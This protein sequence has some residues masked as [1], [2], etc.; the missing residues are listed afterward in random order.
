MRLIDAGRFGEWRLATCIL[1]GPLGLAPCS[2]R[3]RRAWR[4]HP[5]DRDQ[6]GPGNGSCGDRVGQPSAAVP[7]PPPSWRDTPCGF[8]LPY[9]SMLQATVSFLAS[10]DVD[11]SVSLARSKAR[12]HRSR[13]PACMPWVASEGRCVD[14]GGA[15]RPRQCVARACTELS[16]GERRLVGAPRAA[17]SAGGGSS[18]HGDAAAS[19]SVGVVLLIAGERGQPDAG[20]GA[21]QRQL[22]L[23]AGVGARNARGCY[24]R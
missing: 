15:R 23:R 2:C 4:D 9:P 1:P 8:T 14:S 21:G 6:R 24:S 20:R 3:P 16:R 17:A 5:G 13:R 19:G 10:S 11:F 18:A 12:L 7:R 22:A